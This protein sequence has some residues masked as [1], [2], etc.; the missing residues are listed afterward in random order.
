MSAR[1][2]PLALALLT[3]LVTG[4]KGGGTSN[5]SGGAN[6]D[7]SQQRKVYSA[8]VVVSNAPRLG[9][10]MAAEMQRANFQ[11]NTVK[12]LRGS[13]VLSS[14][15]DPMVPKL[16]MPSAPMGGTNITPR[17]VVPSR[18]SAPPSRV[19]IPSALPNIGRRMH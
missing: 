7:Y 12:G 6:T 5:W 4:C 1:S 17:L 2:I 14:A 8:P 16:K 15:A 19:S 9:Q 18:L 3:L 10:R 13:M 11:N